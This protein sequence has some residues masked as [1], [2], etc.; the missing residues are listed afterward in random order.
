MHIEEGVIKAVCASSRK[1]GNKEKYKAKHKSSEIPSHTRPLFTF[2]LFPFSFR[3]YSKELESY[4]VL[5]F[6]SCS[7]HPDLGHKHF[8]EGLNVLIN[9]IFKG[10]PNTLLFGCT[11]TYEATPRC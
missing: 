8:P 11:I 3:Y 1:S 7:F 5:E 9:I 2:G 6:V 10:L 4:R